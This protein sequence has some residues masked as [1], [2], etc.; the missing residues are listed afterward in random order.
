[1]EIP[2]ILKPIITGNIRSFESSYSCKN[3]QKY[4][5][6]TTIRNTEILP[7]KLSSNTQ[8]SYMKEEESKNNLRK[9][10]FIKTH[11]I[12]QNKNNLKLPDDSNYEEI[13]NFINDL[14]VN[15]VPDSKQTFFATSKP[16]KSKIK[17]LADT[18]KGTNKERLVNCWIQEDEDMNFDLLRKKFH[19]GN[20]EE[21]SLLSSLKVR[22]RGELRL[23]LKD[24]EYIIDIH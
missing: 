17:T 7:N 13:V 3:I 19:I 5:I 9:E 6:P 16:N 23:A 20:D 12:E 22:V 18:F 11:P 8:V 4:K 14:K 21:I 15:I 10:R 2:S 1:M 24:P